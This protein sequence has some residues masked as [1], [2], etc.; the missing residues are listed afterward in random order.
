MKNCKHV[1]IFC[2]SLLSF[3]NIVWGQCEQSIILSSQKEVDNFMTDYGCEKIEGSLKIEG[4]DIS[5]LSGLSGITY[6]RDTLSIENNTMLTNI[7]G[8]NALT[9]IGKKLDFRNNDALT[10]I[11]GL[12]ASISGSYKLKNCCTVAPLVK[13]SNH[14]RLNIHRRCGDAEL[15]RTTCNN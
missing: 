4:Y 11:D 8:L 1:F 15:I 14:V 5:N 9:S 13:I 3:S 7:N 2:L 12:S 6:V 10:N